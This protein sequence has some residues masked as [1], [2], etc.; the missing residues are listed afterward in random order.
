[1]PIAEGARRVRGTGP[2]P[3]KVAFY[4]EAPGKQENYRGVPFCGKAGAVLRTFSLWHGIDPDAQFIGNVCQYWPGRGR[5]G[6]DL[7]PDKADLLRDEPV[8]M[9]ELLLVKPRVV[10]ALGEFATK[11][12]LPDNPQDMATLNGLPHLCTRKGL[13]ADLIVIP[14]THP[15]AGL[16]EP[17]KSAETW[18]GLRSASRFLKGDPLAF[19][20]W[21]E[22]TPDVDILLWEPKAASNVSK[23]PAAVDTEGSWKDP[24]GMSVCAL[25]DT[26]ESL[27]ILAEKADHLSF[28]SDIYMHNGKHDVRVLK[29]LGVKLPGF[30]HWEDTMLMGHATSEHP[31]NLK[32][33]AYRLL[34]VKMNHFDKLVAPHLRSACEDYLL[35]LCARVWPDPP[36]ELAFDPKAKEWK[37]KFPQALHTRAWATLQRLQKGVGDPVEWLG[38]AL[39]PLDRA[40]IADADL[41]RVPSL[42]N[43]LNYVPLKDAVQYSGLDAWATAK[44]AP[45]LMAELSRLGRVEA[46]RHD[47]YLNDALVEMES[48]G[49]PFDV[50]RCAS[51]DKDFEKEESRTL[52]LVRSAAKDGKLNPRS[53]LQVS[54]VLTNLGAK[55]RRLTLSGNESTD[56]KTLELLRNDARS[57]PALIQFLDTL[58]QFRGWTKLRS[59]YTLGL[60]EYVKDGRIYPHLSITT[61]I[62][63]RFSSEDP[64]LQNIPSRDAAGMKIRSCFRVVG[65]GKMLLSV[66]LSQIELRLA[67]HLSQDP[68]MVDAFKTGKDLHDLTM[69]QIFK[70]DPRLKDPAQRPFL[71]TPSKTVNFSSLYGI[72]APGLRARFLQMGVTSFSDDDCARFIKGFFTLYPKVR[73]AIDACGLRAKQHGFVTTAAGRARYLPMARMLEIPAVEA[74]AIRQGF[75]HEDQGGASEIIKRALHRWSQSVREACN[76]QTVTKLLLQIHD[77]LL[78]EVEAMSATD[79]RLLQ[80]ARLVKAMLEAD[81]SKYR[82]PI[83]AEVKCGRSWGEMSKLKL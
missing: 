67:A 52:K 41:G 36:S 10:V 19:P 18:L 6:K 38:K 5:D 13:P 9:R 72:S 27:V 39:T 11:W 46:Y 74:E 42:W 29:S 66:D 34:R 60:P 65:E 80:V 50:Q 77:E 21:K 73:E 4:G 51:T 3:A 54:T 37:I 20:I 31:Y 30:T 76:R 71:R 28:A 14:V 15:A 81:S 33:L 44:L 7:H 48:T 62:S 32:S 43:A 63:G 75:N 57:S 68:V 56:E 70:G 24:W 35:E 79:P 17:K 58:L 83:L 69:N 82:V 61:A 59:T 22:V 55:G 45:V 49:L 23:R 25:D 47:Q 53:P 8:V 2:T 64:N 16:H 78:F 12:F 1:V 26:R 40:L